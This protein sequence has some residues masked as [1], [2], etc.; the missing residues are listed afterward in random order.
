MGEPLT[1]PLPDCGAD[2]HLRWTLTV[3]LD[4]I[5]LDA[6]GTDSIGDPM[7]PTDADTATWRVECEAGHVVLLPRDPQCD[8]RCP[9]GE[10]CDAE[11]ES[12]REWRRSD[13]ARLAALL[14]PTGGAADAQR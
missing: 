7:T 5:E 3:G 6:A 8:A 14:P 10:A 4:A 11:D 12:F 1:C 9:G 2:L 13:V